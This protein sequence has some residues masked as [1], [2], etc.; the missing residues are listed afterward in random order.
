MTS[1]ARPR[2]STVGV[3]VL[4]LGGIGATHAQAI[5]R[6]RDEG[7]PIRLVAF[8]GGTRQ[9]AIECSWPGAVQAAPADLL[10]R[11]DVDIVA[12]CTPSSAH[13]EQTLAALRAGKHVV[14][15]KPMALTTDDAAE[16]MELSTRLG[17]VVSP[18]A[19]RRF[20][21]ANVYL[22][23][24]LE[25]GS[26]GRVVLGETFVHWHRP[27]DYYAQAPWRSERDGGGGSLMNQGL[28]NADLL[29][30]LLGGVH[31]VTGQ[32]ATLGHVDPDG[33]GELAVEDTC[34]AT[35]EFTSGALGVIVTTT[36]TPPGEP[37]EVA[38]W[39]STGSFRLNQHGVQH[40]G[41]DHVPPPPAATVAVTGASDPS[42]IGIAGHVDQ[43]RDVAGAV[44]AGTQ[45]KI[46]AADGLATVAVLAGIYASADRGRQVIVTGNERA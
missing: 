45:P 13:A 38:V 30:W 46:T 44:L 9:R 32:R 14:V 20:E 3:G 39:T 40:W 25:Q 8:S 16:I 6:L 2:R 18:L 33:N 34:V 26:L 21:L 35:L 4:G 28:H 1:P 41:F 24:L 27:D 42:A 43:W 22:K 29:C 12:V 31:S 19:Q 5:A 23:S 10:D 7:M 17:L 15:E 36:A 37:A 11:G